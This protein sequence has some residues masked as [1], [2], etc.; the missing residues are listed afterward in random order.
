M[1]S[2]LW[3]CPAFGLEDWPEKEAWTGSAKTLDQLLEELAEANASNKKKVR[4]FLVRYFEDDEDADL[5][6]YLAEEKEATKGGLPALRK[7]WSTLLDSYE[8]LGLPSQKMGRD[9][10]YNE[11]RLALDKDGWTA[12]LYSDADGD[13]PSALSPTIWLAEKFDALF[14]VYGKWF[15]LYSGEP[16]DSCE[17]NR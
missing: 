11:L 13:W 3:R 10:F 9:T 5:R 4:E 2:A 6:A 17:I 14:D 8:I 15:Y 12:R 16:C 7:K 1:S